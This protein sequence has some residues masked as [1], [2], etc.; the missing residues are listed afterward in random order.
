MTADGTLRLELYADSPVVF[1]LNIRNVPKLWPDVSSS[2]RQLSDFVGHHW[3][4][5][6]FIQEWSNADDTRAVRRAREEAAFLGYMY[7]DSDDV[8]QITS[9]GHSVLTFFDDTTASSV[10]KPGNLILPSRLMARALACQSGAQAIWGLMRLC[11]NRLGQE[12]L[13]RAM[14]QIHVLGDIYQVAD[15][16]RDAREQGK[17]EAIGPRTYESDDPK[18]QR[19][20]IT[21]QFRLAGAGGLLIDIDDDP[22]AFTPWA[23][24]IVDEAMRVVKPTLAPST[25]EAAVMTMSRA[26]AAP[27]DVRAADYHPKW[28]LPA[29]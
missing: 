6:A 28:G 9:L 8:L 22:R 18:Q 25:S 24:E 12:E 21:P 16:I 2:L 14:G 7:R 17:P 27:T 11:G 3:D 20:V 15:L 5:E 19:R 23:P 26:A 1:D 29:S 13:N 4:E 10:A